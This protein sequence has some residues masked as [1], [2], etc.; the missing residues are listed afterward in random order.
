MR[1]GSGQRCRRPVYVENRGFP[2]LEAETNVLA[3]GEC[4]VT[5]DT[6]TRVEVGFTLL[7]LIH[8]RQRLG[9]RE[10]DGVYCLMNVV[11]LQF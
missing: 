2:W 7:P 1:Q 10:E 5:Q 11:S 4:H 6:D 8:T 3:V 9:E